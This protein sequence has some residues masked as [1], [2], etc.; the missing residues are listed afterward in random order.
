MTCHLRKLKM[1]FFL[2]YFR[3]VGNHVT[4]KSAIAQSEHKEHP[5]LYMRY[6]ASKFCINNASPVTSFK[7]KCSPGGGVSDRDRWPCS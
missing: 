2:L 5:P 6:K 1:H 4:G 3:T 7:I